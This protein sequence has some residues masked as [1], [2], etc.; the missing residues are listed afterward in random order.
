MRTECKEQSANSERRYA[1][2]E[3][4]VQ[5]GDK[6][7]VAGGPR[8][9]AKRNIR[10]PNNPRN[11]GDHAVDLDERV[12]KS[13]K[14]EAPNFEGQLNPKVFLDRL[15]DMDHFFAWYEMS[16]GRKFRFAKMKLVGQAKLYWTNVERQIESLSGMR[17]KRGFVKSTFH[18]LIVNNW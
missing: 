2:L 6:E 1:Q 14:V 18:C 12:M 13:V 10:Q 9:Q 17:R 8:L 16:E 5:N 3:A 7:S 4:A 15:A 11:Y